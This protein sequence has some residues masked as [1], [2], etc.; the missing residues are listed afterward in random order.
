MPEL[1]ALEVL[2][3]IGH[4]GSLSAA[5]RE[6]GL[7][8]QSVSARLRS[9]E[10]QTGVQ[11]VLRTARGSE[12]TQTG[13]VVAEWANQLIGVAQGIDAAIATLRHDARARVKVAA[14]QTIA[15]QLMPRW[16]VS[17]Q[18]DSRRHTTPVVDVVLTA[19]N[20][21]QV[22]AAVQTS[23]ADMGFIEGPGVPKRM[24]SRIIGHDE[25]VVIVAPTHKWARRTA[26]ISSEELSRTPLVSREQGSGTRE[27]LAQAL[28]NCLGDAVEQTAPVMEL[29]SAA[30][31]RAAVLAGAGPAVV[32]RLSVVDDLVS[33][34]LQTVRVANLDLSRNLRAIWLGPQTP[35]GGAVRDLLNH[36]LRQ[37][38]NTSA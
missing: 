25:L 22:I 16:M 33:K 15:E 11:L 35:P 7:T 2:L 21:D 17:M 10:S 31:I 18:A 6:L 5:G 12:L 38:E 9:L 37:R 26:P 28:R 30:A 1:S 24:R 13:A 23:D 19:M 36:I 4:T 20:S 8:Q 29:S 34:R 3:A 32:S 14:S 27:S